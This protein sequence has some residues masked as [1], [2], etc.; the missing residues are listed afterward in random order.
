MDPIKQGAQ[1]FRQVADQYSWTETENIN[2]A[3][4][5]LDEL[6]KATEGLVILDFLDAGNW[7]CIEKIEIED[8]IMKITWHDYRN[9]QESN[10]AKELRSLAFP[11]ELYA[12]IIR[13]YE[14]KIIKVK[15]TAVFLIRGYA[16]KDKEIKKAVG[17]GADEI[18]IYDEKN[19]FSRRAAVRRRDTIELYDCINTPIFSLVIVPKGA[20]TSSGRSRQAL[21]AVNMFE[22]K[23][24]LDKV[25]QALENES[26]NDKDI[27]CEKANTVRRIFENILKIELCYRHRQVDI[28]KDYSDLLLG[29]LVKYV[30]DFKDES[31][32]SCLTQIAILANELSHD[33]GKPIIR[34]KALLLVTLAIAYSFL[35]EFEIK[36]IPYPHFD[37]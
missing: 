8:D 27:I 26:L 7:D 37:N 15:D 23:N 35:L 20:G 3:K 29:D 13:F 4:E 19:L 21:Y 14:L 34:V 22:A 9:K 25:R 24:R 1:I 5:C 30:K 6:L 36:N 16:L 31:T 2:E 11:A 33:S 32:S 18:K 17:T 10:I 12:L 28:K